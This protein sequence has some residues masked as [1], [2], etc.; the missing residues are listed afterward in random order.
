MSKLLNTIYLFL[1]MIGCFKFNLKQPILDY[2]LV[3]IP[4]MVYNGQNEKAA[5]AKGITPIQ[6]QTPITPINVNAINKIPIT[7]RIIR[8]IVPTFN[9]MINS[10]QFIFQKTH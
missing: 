3:L 1:L 8:S 4:N 6:P 10:S 7:A 5:D 9:F 2:F